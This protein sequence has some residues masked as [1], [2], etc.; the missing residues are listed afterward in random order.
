MK[1]V[2]QFFVVFGQICDQS[3][4]F[5]HPSQPGALKPPVPVI[6]LQFVVL[7]LE[8]GRRSLWFTMKR[9]QSVGKD[10]NKG[11]QV[12]N[13]KVVETSIPTRFEVVDA[14]IVQ[15][16]G[17]TYLGAGMTPAEEEYPAFL[18]GEDDIRRTKVP[19]VDAM[20]VME[21][22]KLGAGDFEGLL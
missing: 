21:L 8:N 3:V 6:I 17:H 2:I 20:L 15:L 18:T 1:G 5:G 10:E 9:G 22:N 13:Q 7:A 12:A 19:L 16:A 11:Q 4:Q 14:W